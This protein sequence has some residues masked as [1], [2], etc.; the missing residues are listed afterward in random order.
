MTAEQPGWQLE[1][2]SA[3]LYERYLVPP[4]TLPWAR[5]LVGRVGLRP[6]DRVLDVACGTGAVARIAAAAVGE[7]G[8]VAAVD[9][10]RGMLAVGRS[11]QPPNGA[12]IEWHEG[13][14]DELPFGDGQ[15]DI[16]LCQLGLQFFPDRPAALREMGRVLTNTGRIG[17]SVYTAI[18]R[19]P[20]A[21]A[22]ANAL[23]RQLGAGASDAKRSEHSLAD[24]DDLCRL[25]EAAGFAA[26]QVET[27]TQSVHFA[28]VETW[29]EVQF[30]A[31]PLAALVADRE[32]SE[33][34]RI[35]GLVSAD[36]SGALTRFASEDAFSFPQ[37]AN[38]VLADASRRARRRG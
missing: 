7:A 33:R 13:S 36:V 21:N 31:T 9:V 24:P 28:S 6:G 12:R 5:D 34:D 10:N 23:D 8:N 29:V 22:L 37:Q 20:A 3:E 1:Q 35:I 32:P 4:V 14:A 19:N 26:V 15:F 38:V 17:V 27:V 30:V 25:V 11:I 18:R 2:V 16:V